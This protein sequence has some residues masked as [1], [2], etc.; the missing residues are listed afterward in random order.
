MIRQ[1]TSADFSFFYELYFHPHINPFLLY[2]YMSETEFQ[3]I[4]DDLLSK[5]ALYVFEFEGK[6]VGMFKL[7]Q[8]GHRMGHIAYIG[9][10]AIHPDWAGKGLGEAM[11]HGIIELGRTRG[12]LRLE[13]TTATFNYKA[14][15]LYEKVGFEKEG[16]MRN[17]THLVS[18]G[19]FIDEVLMAYLYPPQ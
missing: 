17:L 13:L 6:S 5:N 19:R 4:F 15:R 18:E 9:G 3:P 11:M 12:V 10:L 7:L 1:A 8:H 16:V 2:E 14:I